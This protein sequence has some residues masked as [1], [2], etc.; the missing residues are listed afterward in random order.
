VIVGNSDGGFLIV[1]SDDRDGG[2][3]MD[4]FATAVAGSG[5]VLGYLGG[6]AICTAA[7]AQLAPVLCTDGADGAFVAWYDSRN[8]NADAWAL[9][10]GSAGAVASGWPAQ[11]L[12]LATGSSSQTPPS[13]V[14]DGVGGCVVSIADDAAI[15]LD[16]FATRLTVFGGISEGWSAETPVST[17]FGDQYGAPCV[18]NGASGAI[19]VWSDN[20]SLESDLYAQNID[21]WGK[22]G[23]AAP[24]L[25]SVKDVLGDQ[26]GQ[27]RVSWNASYLDASP[28]FA[29]G[30]YWLWRQVPAATALADLRTGR[31]RLLHDGEAPDARP[32]R[33][34]RT[35]TSPT[36]TSVVYWEYVT[37][38]VANALASY[39]LVASTTTDSTAEGN[40]TTLFMVEARGA[41]HQSWDSASL[42]GYS[43]DDLAPPAPQPFVASYAA[44][45]THLEWTPPAAPDLAGYRLYRGTS[46]G[47][48]PDLAHRIA[49]PSDAFFTDDPG[50]FYDYKVSA[51]DVHGNEGPTSLAF[52]TGTTAVGD[53]PR[54]PLALDGAR[55]NPLHAGGAIRWSQPRAE[56]VRVTLVDLAGRR[57]R[58]FADGETPAG[59]HTVRWN[60]RDDAGRMVADGIYFLELEAEGRK[61]ETRVAVLR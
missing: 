54:L 34:L 6:G 31:A 36:T 56:H 24:T 28:G 17:A 38:Q 19:F 40:P 8:G 49:S 18:T 13:I 10:L 59:A 53:S 41:G 1:W 45:V 47:F 37:S 7:S 22:L 33:V 4:L 3:T 30:S 25:V 20:R 50:G 60:E 44:G 26:G 55:P 23:D 46:P 15:R 14:A 52:P 9:H 48:T 5:F 29:I 27:V 12:S 11:G 32:G 51:V 21:R 43:V 42:A 57:V 35:S 39:S 2:G 58:T 16:V 61:L